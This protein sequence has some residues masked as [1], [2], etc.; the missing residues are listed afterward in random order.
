MKRIELRYD[1]KFACWGSLGQNIWNKMEKPSK[2]EQDNKNL[3][4]AFAGFFNCYCQSLTSG[5]ETDTGLCLQPN[6]RLSDICY[7]FKTLGLKLLGNQFGNLHTKFVIRDSKCRFTCSEL[8]LYRLKH[9]KVAKYFDS[10]CIT[11]NMR[12]GSKWR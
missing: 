5:R 9:R 10:N 3:I 8:E 12:N 7:F 2:I 11:K 4:S 6:L 1:Q